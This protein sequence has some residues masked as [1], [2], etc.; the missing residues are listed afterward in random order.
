SLV[1]A[2]TCPPLPPCPPPPPP[3][4]PALTSFGFPARPPNVPSDA[5]PVRVLA[6]FPPAKVPPLE[7]PPPPPPIPPDPWSVPPVLL[8]PSPPPC[9]IICALAP[10]AVRIENSGIAVRAV[11]AISAARRELRCIFL[12]LPVRDSVCLATARLI[13]NRHSHSY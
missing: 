5:V 10:E 4:P 12:L 9:V 13:T 1:P 6:A 7:P 2:S 3:P 8:P 11:L